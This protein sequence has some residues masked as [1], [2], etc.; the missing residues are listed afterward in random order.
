MPY[1]EFVREATRQLTICNA[2]RYCEGYCAVFPA[3]ELRRAFEEADV[4]HLAQLCHDCRACYYACMFTPPHE[5]G[6]NIPQVM[7]AIREQTYERHT[8]PRFMAALYRS[9]AAL[10]AV[11]AGGVLL[12][13]TAAWWLAGPRLLEPQSGPGAFYRVIPH[14]AMLVLGFGLGTYTVAVWLISASRFWQ[15]TA[16]GAIRVRTRDLLAAVSDAARLRW[17]VGGGPGCPYPGE[18][19]AFGRRML[20]AFVFYGFIAAVAST[21]SAAFYQEVWGRLPPYPVFSLPVVLGI[22]GGVS[23]VL[24]CSGLFFL[25]RRS[26]PL[27]AARETALM[28]YGFLFVLGMTNVTGLLTLLVRSSWLMGLV[29]AVHLGFVAVLYVTMAH[30]KFVHAIYRVLALVRNSA[31]QARP[32]R[33]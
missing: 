32:P 7:S 19:P 23:M 28:D 30:G 24:G 16:L 9:P 13:M 5:F 29:L 17:L 33:P 25:K 21:S 4:I 2:C 10:A 12:V 18:P 31:E 14:W 1:P 20:H 15:S 8:W 26:D 6:V 11:V 22:V 27:P 3:M